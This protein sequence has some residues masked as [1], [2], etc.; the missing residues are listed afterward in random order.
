MFFEFILVA[1]INNNPPI[2]IDEHRF[3]SAGNCASVAQELESYLNN[4]LKYDYTGTMKY[5]GEYLI[6]DIIEFEKQFG[7]IMPNARTIT[8]DDN[9]FRTYQLLNEIKN[10]KANDYE[11]KGRKGSPE[12]KKQ[13]D[14]I[15]QTLSTFMDYWSADYEQ[16]NYLNRLNGQVPQLS[17]NYV[18]NNNTNYA[19]LAVP[20]LKK[21]PGSP[22][23]LR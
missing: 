18:I 17:K 15:H 3:S 4:G 2:I 12:L 14:E 13:I 16:Q 9:P 19:C 22:S 6:D 23:P 20:S 21:P 11:F 8:N 7:E 10:I 1:I 5:A